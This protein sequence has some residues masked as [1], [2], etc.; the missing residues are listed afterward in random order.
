MLAMP[1]A[2][3]RMLQ[4][5][6]ARLPPGSQLRRRG[7]KRV[8]ALTWA[9]ANRE[10]FEVPLLFYEP[11]TE[12]KIPAEFARTLGLAE[13]YHGH[14]GFLEG[15][16]DLRQDAADLRFEPERIID[17]GDRVAARVTAFAVG[18]SS[19]AALKETR[20]SVL[21]FSP[22]GLIARHEFYLTWE[23]ALAVLERRD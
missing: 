7:L 17:L 23:E 18:R 20:G 14:H 8:A 2:L 3:L 1:T 4:R 13:T 9:A 19:G 11:D 12:A 5:G 16:R 15:W 10:D 21:Y 22:R 6:F